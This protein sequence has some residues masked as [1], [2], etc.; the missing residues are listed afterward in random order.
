MHGIHIHRHRIFGQR[1]SALKPVVMTPVSI[2]K[3]TASITLI[4]RTE[5]VGC[6]PHVAL[7]QRFLYGI[8]TLSIEGHCPNVLVIVHAV[9]NR[10]FEDG[11]I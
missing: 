2:Q 7:A 5:L 1:F 11:R 3:G 6:R 4:N 10:L 9:G 8:R